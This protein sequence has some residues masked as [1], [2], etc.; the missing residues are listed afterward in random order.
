M[1]LPNRGTNSTYALTWSLAARA[2]GPSEGG[3]VDLSMNRKLKVPR[4]R[5]SCPRLH[6]SV[7]I[8]Q[9]PLTVRDV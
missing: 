7:L 5:V 2:R 6:C 9:K 8:L 4:S 3:P 1:D